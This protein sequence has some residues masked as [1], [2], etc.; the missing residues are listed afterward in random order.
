M[1]PI[2]LW[3][4]PDEAMVNVYPRESSRHDHTDGAYCGTGFPHMLFKV[5]PEYGP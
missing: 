3:D 1:L 2:G 5:H 4:V